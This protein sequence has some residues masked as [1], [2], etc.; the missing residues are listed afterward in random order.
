MEQGAQIADRRRGLVGRIEKAR[1][2]QIVFQI[3]EKLEQLLARGGLIDGAVIDAFG[4]RFIRSLKPLI[5]S[6]SAKRPARD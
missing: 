6:S 2:Q 5:S 3:R 1:F 4:G